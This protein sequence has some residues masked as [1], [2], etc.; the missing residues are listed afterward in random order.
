M[1]VFADRID[2]LD[3]NYITCYRFGKPVQ[4]DTRKNVVIK[5]DRLTEQQIALA[6]NPPKNE[7][8]NV[9]HTR[10]LRS[11]KSKGESVQLIPTKQLK[12]L[13]PAANRKSGKKD[14][15]AYPYFTSNRTVAKIQFK[16][17]D[18]VWCKLKGHPKW[19]AKV[20]EICGKNGQLIKLTWFNDYRMSQVNRGQ[21]SKFNTVESIPVEVK[22]NMKLQKAIK[23]AIIYH[24]LINH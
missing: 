24:K 23:E 22:K 13:V 14:D 19:P 20:D 10:C 15:Q 4:Y 3:K 16:I 5:L 21:V 17:N 6:C 8:M 11:S 7:Q 1:E 18:V 2:P 9:D 12:P